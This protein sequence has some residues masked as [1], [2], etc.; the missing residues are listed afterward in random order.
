MKKICMVA[1]FPPPIHGL[2]YA[3]ET[4]Y[5]SKL[6]KYYKL[7]KVDI[8]NNKKFLR[9]CFK[10]LK[11]DADLFYFTIS[12]SKMGNY[13]DLVYLFLM[14]IKKRQV[15]I[16]L[17]G[18]G[19]GY[20]YN[21]VFSNMQKKLNKILLSNVNKAIVLSDELKINFNQLIDDNKIVAIQNFVENNI[22]L[23]ELELEKIIKTKKEKQQLQI[24]Y[25]SNFIKEK[26]YQEVLKIAKQLE[27]RNDKRFKFV[28]AGLFFDNKEKEVFE[29]LIKNS[30]FKDFVEYRGPVYGKEKQQLLSE[31]DIFILLTYYINEGQPIS[32]IEAMAN[33]QAIISTKHAG[34]PF[35]VNKNGGKLFHYSDLDKI[36]DYLDFLYNNR[37]ELIKISINNINRVKNEFTKE[38]H[39]DNMIN[40]FRECFKDE[41]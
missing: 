26:G 37:D 9:N 41:V 14:I 6:K 11:S 7:E 38:K 30:R 1:Q 31:S 4:L 2:S 39:I 21:N 22:N 19:F 13:R 25:L 5:N 16:H 24:L 3:V 8:K 10:I 34:I 27:K 15:V 35:L 40:L 12:Q 32:I 33:G 17:H 23:N 36:I 29:T 20:L 28:F 18:G